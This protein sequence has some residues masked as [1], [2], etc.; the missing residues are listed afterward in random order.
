M[1]VAALVDALPGLRERLL[2]ELAAVQP[3]GIAAPEF[4]ELTTGGLRA[5]GFGLARRPAP[6]TH[7]PRRTRTRS[8]D[9]RTRTF[10]RPRTPRMRRTPRRP[11]TTAATTWPRRHAVC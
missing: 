7:C 1:F 11:G 10:R 9:T 3:A 2:G 5:C 6:G 8:K 4:R